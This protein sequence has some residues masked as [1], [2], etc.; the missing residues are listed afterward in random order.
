MICIVIRTFR[1]SFLAYVADMI[2]RLGVLALALPFCTYVAEVIVVRIHTF[3]KLK[4]TKIANMVI[5]FVLAVYNWQTAI[6]ANVGFVLVYAFAESETA[7]ITLV[8]SFVI[9]GAGRD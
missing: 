1:Y 7:N 3:C 2:N 6:I 4:V 8:I 9:Y 5:I